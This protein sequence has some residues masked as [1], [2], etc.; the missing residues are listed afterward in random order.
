MELRIPVVDGHPWRGSTDDVEVIETTPGT[1]EQLLTLLRA[2]GADYNVM[3]HAPVGR[4]DLVSALRGHPVEHAAKCLMLVLKLDRTTRKYV[5]AVVPGNRKVD[6]VAVR[7]LYRA[8]YAGF[9]DPATAERLARTVAGTVLPFA[10]DQS[11][12]L[13]VDP[14]VLAQ[15]RMYFNAARLDRSISLATADYARIGRPAVHTIAEPD[16]SPRTPAGDQ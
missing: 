3:D 15:P 7:N 4:T 8:R 16:Q 14:D 11:V 12:E 13:V 5:L 1:Y 10:L 2:H 9:C 6:L